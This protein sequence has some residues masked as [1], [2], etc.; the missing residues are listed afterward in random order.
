MRKKTKKKQPTHLYF[1]EDVIHD[2]YSEE[3]ID[4]EFHNPH[5]YRVTLPTDVSTD[6][7]EQDEYWKSLNGPVITYSLSELNKSK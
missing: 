3:Y 1:R 7:K 4:R 5:R 6:W 2:D